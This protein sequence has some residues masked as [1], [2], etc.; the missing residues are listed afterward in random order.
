MENKKLNIA[1]CG[2]G[3]FAAK[4]IVPAL[5]KCNNIE[6]SAIVSKSS[7]QNTLN[8][9]IHRYHT[10][11]D[12]IAS[13]TVD[14]VYI[15][16]PNHLH[17]EQAMLCLKAGL[18]VLCE[19]PMATNYTDCQ[20][21][22]SIA[23]KMNVHLG[24]G[25]MLR[26]SP[27]LKLARKWV[28]DGLI[29]EVLSCDVVFHYD[30]PESNRSWMNN[31][32]LSGGGVLI[33]AGIHC[34]DVIR[35]FLGNNLITRTAKTDSDLHKGGVE[36]HALLEFTC[37]SVYGSI[38]LSSKSDYKSFLELS[39]SQGIISI[40]SF[41]ATW[42]SVTVTL[43]DHNKSE[44]LKESVVDVSEIYLTQLK[45]FANNIANITTS[46]LD[47]SA[48]ENVKIVEEFYSLANIQ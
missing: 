28:N 5:E 4:R 8:S 24:V 22:L 44:I 39:G 2:M 17:A 27:A 13:K 29:G 12:L 15:A 38:D 23:Q 47:Y 31:K 33:D 43:Y 6:L 34:I 25:H 35:L 40:E 16:S 1:I 14:A 42:E 18:H 21:M 3:R 32:K 41:A 37:D 20:S 46:S 10:L 19:K 11:D 45:E 30:L 26:F 7:K 48:A 36:R 9:T